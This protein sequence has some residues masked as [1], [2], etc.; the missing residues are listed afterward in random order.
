MAGATRRYC[1]PDVLGFRI[2]LK[3]AL[4]YGSEHGFWEYGLEDG[5]KHGS[6]CLF[7]VCPVRKSG[8]ATSRSNTCSRRESMM[9][10]SGPPAGILARRS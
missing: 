1:R 2:G 3:C 5:P 10:I 8:A 6:E 9:K 4:E 7:A